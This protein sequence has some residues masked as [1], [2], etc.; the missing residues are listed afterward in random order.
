M[1]NT[2]EWSGERQT[3]EGACWRAEISLYLGWDSVY[4]KIVYVFQDLQKYALKRVNFTVYELILKKKSKCGCFLCW[5][6]DGSASVHTSVQRLYILCSCEFLLFP[7]EWRLD[8]SIALAGKVISMAED[9]EEHDLKTQIPPLSLGVNTLC[10]RGQI[11]PTTC[12]CK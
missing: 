3:T 4:C 5:E 11:K 6:Q 12:F 8:G 9:K 10:P 7:E 2:E 1:G